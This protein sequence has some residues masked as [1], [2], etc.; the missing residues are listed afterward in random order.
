[1]SVQ[2]GGL[3]SSTNHHQLEALHLEQRIC[4]VLD[5]HTHHKLVQKALVRGFELITQ[6]HSIDTPWSTVDVF[7]QG[8]VKICEILLDVRRSRWF[9][10]F[11][12]TI[13]CCLQKRPGPRF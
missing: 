9:F 7:A 10:F 2:V 12:R 13:N 8:Q 1:M 3:L 4:A 6:L 11:R 5:T